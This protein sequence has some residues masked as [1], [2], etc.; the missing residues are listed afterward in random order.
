MEKFIVT[1]SRLFI[2][3]YNYDNIFQYIASNVINKLI[4]CE[5]KQKQNIPLYQKHSENKKKYKKFQKKANRNS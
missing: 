4:K 5:E 2:N 3:K 1:N